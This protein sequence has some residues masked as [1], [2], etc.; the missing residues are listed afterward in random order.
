[1]SAIGQCRAGRGSE[2]H[3]THMGVVKMKSLAREYIW[4]PGL[5]KEIESTASKCKGCARFR[6]KPAPVPLT[7]WPWATRPM[8]RVHVDFAEYK[9]VQLLIVI[10]AFF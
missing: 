9:G 8:E 5:N 3:A 6:K 2:L 10:D 4:W 7:H 1:M